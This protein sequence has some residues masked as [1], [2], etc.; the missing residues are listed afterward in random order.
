MATPM[1]HGCSWTK[2]HPQPW[3]TILLW[4]WQCWILNPL[5]QARNKP[6]IPPPPVPLYA[7]SFFFFFSIFAFVDHICSIWN[8]QGLG[9]NRSYS[10]WPMPQPQQLHIWAVSVTYTT[11]HSN[12]GS[13]IQWARPG[14]EPTSSWILTGFVNHW[15]MKGTPALIFLIH[16]TT[17]ETPS[18]ILFL[19]VFPS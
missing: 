4:L 18:C 11:A 15:A 16:C 8:F 7:D 13:L 19:A 14:I 12:A 2:S 9:S 10:H 17:A 6:V 1:T 5:P 3:P